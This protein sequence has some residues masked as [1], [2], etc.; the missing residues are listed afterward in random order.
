MGDPLTKVCLHLV[1]ILVRKVGESYATPEFLSKVFPQKEVEV[2]QYIDSYCK[3]PVP[4]E[5]V[6]N[7]EEA[8]VPIG[9]PTSTVTGDQI[10]LISF[11]ANLNEIQLPEV[12]SEPESVP[13]PKEAAVPVISTPIPKPVVLA[14]A[15]TNPLGFTLTDEWLLRPKKALVVNELGGTDVIININPAKL[16]AP[17]NPASAR[18]FHFRCIKLKNILIASERDSNRMMVVDADN[19]R[20]TA[21]QEGFT[22]TLPTRRTIPTPVPVME[23]VTVQVPLRHPTGMVRTPQRRSTRSRRREN[24]SPE[25]DNEDCTRTTCSIS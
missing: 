10:P 16:R 13:L 9:E 4:P 23:T 12:R 14:R 1:N 15:S 19:A 24:S 3:D 2:K 6:M 21:L 11:G 8:Y 17:A 5:F 20:H 7:I 18:E 22:W 25:S